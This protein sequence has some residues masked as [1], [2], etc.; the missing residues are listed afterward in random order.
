MASWDNGSYRP[1]RRFGVA[2][3]DVRYEREYLVALAVRL[4]TQRARSLVRYL[5]AKSTP[6]RTHRLCMRTYKDVFG[7]G[8]PEEATVEQIIAHI[9]RLAAS[10]DRRSS[11]DSTLSSKGVE[12]TPTTMECAPVWA[13][14]PATAY[15]V[16]A[17]A[18]GKGVF[19]LLFSLLPSGNRSVPELLL[20][21]FSLFQ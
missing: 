13:Q 5:R 18:Y 2:S 16:A 1:G 10:T 15:V 20:R 8:L 7:A 19:D 9:D 12:T 14:K 21:M 4:S 6:H 3:D 11:V 17:A